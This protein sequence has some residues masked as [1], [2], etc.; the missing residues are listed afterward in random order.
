MARYVNILIFNTMLDANLLDEVVSGA[1]AAVKR[2]IELRDSED[3][4]IVLPYS[5]R[6]EVKNPRTPPQVRAMSDQF[7]YSV[8]VDL[9]APQIAYYER[10]VRETK[11][12]SQLKN[13]ERDLYHIFET[14]KHGGGHFVTRDTWLLKNAERIWELAHVEIVTPEQFIEKAET[15]LQARR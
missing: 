5:V 3:I 9:T 15:A 1:N 13:V 11:G 4:D 12:N 2:I 8:P 14:G 10:L 7:I 6:D